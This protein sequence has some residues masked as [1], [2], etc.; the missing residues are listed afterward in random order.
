MTSTVRAPARRR[1]LTADRR[2]RT[3]GRRES[4]TVR[5]AVGVIAVAVLDDAFVHREP[6]TSIGD[7]LAS[8]LIPTAAAIALA[9][10]YPRLRPGTRATSVLVCGVL[11]IVAG[12]VDGVRHIAVDRLSGDDVT[13][14]LGLG[15]GIAL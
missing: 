2:H 4:L 3:A 13:A 8:G 5:I 10:A 14:L 1:A 11:A 6:G 7:H 12:V 15:A 9:V